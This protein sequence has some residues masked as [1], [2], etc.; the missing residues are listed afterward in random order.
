MPHGKLRARQLG[1]AAKIGHAGGCRGNG[2]WW[3]APAK[4]KEPKHVLSHR[5][6]KRH[7]LDYPHC[8]MVNE[9]PVIAA[10]QN[11]ALNEIGPKPVA[12]NRLMVLGSANLIKW[13]AMGPGFPTSSR[14]GRAESIV[15]LPRE[16]AWRHASKCAKRGPLDFLK[17]CNRSQMLKVQPKQITGTAERCQY[18]DML[19]GTKPTYHLSFPG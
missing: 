15:L 12:R 2:T 17:S 3:P 14:P 19:D 6:I 1:S 11:G 7:S 10:W 4:A 8:R 16:G 18:T 5:M 9:R 13:R